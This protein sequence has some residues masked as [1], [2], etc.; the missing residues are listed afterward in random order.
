MSRGSAQRSAHLGDV[1]VT[2]SGRRQ[3]S[4]LVKS[5]EEIAEEQVAGWVQKQQAAEMAQRAKQIAEVQVASWVE[6][7]DAGASGADAAFAAAPKM[8]APSPLRDGPA[9]FDAPAPVRNDYAAAAMGDLRQP[10][11]FEDSPASKAKSEKARN[12]EHDTPR[13][14]QKRAEV[15]AN[16][17]EAQAKTTPPQG[18]QR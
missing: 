8:L 6:K 11:L 4:L 13:T 18:A 15:L 16:V 9:A 17:L 2:S 1:L 5:L 12:A 10:S 7:Q 14:A 3:V